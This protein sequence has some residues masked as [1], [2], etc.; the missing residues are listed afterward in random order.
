M[1]KIP[2]FLTWLLLLLTLVSAPAAAQDGEATED[3]NLTDACVTD[4]DPDMDYFPEKVEIRDAVNFDVTYFNHYKVV[5]VTGSLSTF[6]YVLVQCGTPIPDA[7]DFPEGTQFIEV[8]AGDIITFSTTFLPGLVE[9]GL[10]DKLVGMGNTS[11]TS[12]PEIIERIDAGDI[13]E[14]SPNFELDLERIL[15]AEPDLVMTDDFDPDRFSQFTE[16]GIFTAVNTDYLEATPLGRAEWL[17]FIAL[18]YNQEAP[19]QAAYDEIVIAYNEA[20]DLAATVAEEDRP[21]V[22]WNS[23]SAFSEAWSIPGHDTYAGRLIEDA[24]GIIALGEEAQEGSALLSFEVVYDQGLDADIWIIN[25]FAVRTI[26]DLVAI[27]ERYADFAAVQ[28]ETVWNNDGDIGP[29]GGNNYFELG[30]TN[31][32]LILQDLVALFHPE[33]L[34]DHEFTFYLPLDSD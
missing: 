3:A 25:A 2:I 13:V 14:V 9:L 17:K 19:A 22:L 12:T 6:D 31:P 7:E 1:N 24:G 20:A 4:F 18:F 33:L 27:D 23:Y 21:T 10:T 11:F 28:N 34:P 5:T 16:L 15:A 30:V 29:S 32:H 26:A 8:P